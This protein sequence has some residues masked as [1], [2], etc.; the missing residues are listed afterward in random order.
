VNKSEIKELFFITPRSNLASILE[1]GIL[2]N[3]RAARLGTAPIS[4]AM[5]EIQERRDARRV[6]SGLK[7]HQYANLYINARNPMLYKRRNS[8][9]QIGV[10]SVSRRVL[11][12]PDVVVTDGNAA[13]YA[14]RFDEARN[15][16]DIIDKNLT[17]AHDWTDPDFY[18]YINKKRAVCAE[19]LV[20]GV[21]SP[22]YIRG[23]Y[24]SCH[25]A[26]R[27]FDALGLRVKFKVDAYLFFRG[28]PP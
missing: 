12:L 8:H 15:G 21:V 10:I 4:I 16:L 5:P 1:R 23:V 27:E 9:L 7:L 20:P 25:E 17:F 24:V 22:E 28:A 19:V 6:P 11:D 3:E 2:S 14:T 26:L 13:S 18:E